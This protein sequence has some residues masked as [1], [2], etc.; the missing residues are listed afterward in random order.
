MP[1]GT[2]THAS[3]YEKPVLKADGEPTGEIT[4]EAVPDAETYGWRDHRLEG[5][6]A[7]E[8]R[9]WFRV[10]KATAHDREQLEEW[11]ADGEEPPT[12]TGGEPFYEIRWGCPLSDTHVIVETSRG[13]I[14]AFAGRPPPRIWAGKAFFEYYCAAFVPWIIPD[15]GELP[16]PTRSHEEEFTAF[17][18]DLEDDARLHQPLEEDEHRA[19][20]NRHLHH[21]NVTAARKIAAGRLFEIQNLDEGFRDIA[22]GACKRHTDHLRR[23][24]DLWEDVGRPRTKGRGEEDEARTKRQLKK[25]RDDIDRKLESTVGMLKKA[26]NYADVV[27]DLRD[28]HPGLASSSTAAARWSRAPVEARAEF[29]AAFEAA[30]RRGPGPTEV[31]A[32]GPSPDEVRARLKENHDAAASLRRDAMDQT[33][34]GGEGG[35]SDPAEAFDGIPLPDALRMRS[36]AEVRAAMDEWV[37]QGKRGSPPLNGDQQPVAAELYRIVKFRNAAL[38]RGRSAAEIDEDLRA[39]GR[40][41][42]VLLVG[43]GGTGKSTVI[44]KLKEIFA[45]EGLGTIVVTAFTGVAASVFGAP[46]LLTLFGQG[47]E[48]KATKPL[49]DLS[50]EYVLKVKGKFK[51]HA[52]VDPEDVA[53]LVIDEVSFNDDA[54]FGHVENCMRAL[55]DGLRTTRGGMPLLLAGDNMQKPPPSQQPWYKRLVEGRLQPAESSSF[56]GM[57]LLKSARRFTLRTIMRSADDEEFSNAQKA[58]RDPEVAHPVTSEF[59]KRIRKL[60]SSD[61]DDPRWRFAPI[62]VTSQIE[63]DYLNVRQIRAFAEYFE[64]PLI[65]WRKPL[66][67][68]PVTADLSEDEIDELYENEPNLWHYFVEGAPGLMTEALNSTRALANG[69]P[70]LFDSLHY[71]DELP[72]NLHQAYEQRGFVE[73]ALATGDEP[74]VVYVRVGSTRDANGRPKHFW[75][76]VRRYSRDAFESDR[77]HAVDATWSLVASHTGTAFLCRTCPGISCPRAGRSGTTKRIRSSCPSSWDRRRRSTIRHGSTARFLHIIKWPTVCA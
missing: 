44:D 69:T 47:I 58:M 20:D 2:K 55:T 77:L 26:D 27:R 49:A 53:L 8:F 76:A 35:G 1:E 14:V 57:S 21:G 51:K 71:T 37:R 28:S 50:P 12:T 11:R 38:R 60:S 30:D 10:R 18:A 46:T 32:R 72:E 19:G 75:Y 62:G 41:G 5:L 45:N 40:T 22:Y 68:M 73:V 15:S 56:R 61:V 48:D 43:A 52:G 67:H 16:T 70:F 33:P 36:P 74:E 24:R 54:T 25:V 17:V 42:A 6:N 9:R 64:L 31:A 39:A 66:P 63:R 4:H 34:D 13:G 29:A 3:V 59:F 7:L 65:K 23:A